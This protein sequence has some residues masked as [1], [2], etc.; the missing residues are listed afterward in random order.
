MD[1]YIPEDRLRIDTFLPQL[2]DQ[3]IPRTFPDK[4]AYA[5]FLTDILKLDG[6]S[7]ESRLS[8]GEMLDGLVEKMLD[9]KVVQPEM[10]DLIIVA[11]RE[12]GGSCCPGL[13]QYLHYKHGFTRA[14]IIQLSGNNCSNVEFAIDTACQLLQGYR[15]KNILVAAVSRMGRPEDRI[16][17]SY[18]LIGDGAGIIL[19]SK[20]DAVLSQKSSD[21]L[22]NGSL[23]DVD[24]DQDN[25]IALFKFYVECL[26]NIQR[27]T[28][29]AD[30]QISHIIVQNANPLLVIPC[31]TAAGLNPDKVFTS[32]FGR[33]GHLDCVDIIVNLTDILQTQ[34][35]KDKYLLTFGTGMRGSYISMIFKPC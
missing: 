26:E 20:N 16:V 24:L 18:A 21:I 34:V 33:F 15:F 25:S 14:Y 29:V 31:I 23:H 10:I 19:L 28:S 6:V 1:Y 32:N 17:G 4:Q 9:N 5:A 7:C 30:N 12:F 8:P 3:Y 22:V 13:G 27:K 2:P 35:R 11:E